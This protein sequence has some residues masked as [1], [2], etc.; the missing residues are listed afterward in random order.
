[1]TQ[2]KAFEHTL[3]NKIHKTN[4]PPTITKYIANYI[5]GRKAYT[6]FN[7]TQSKQRHLKTGVP[8]GG[9]L[10]PILFN[11]YMSDLPNP[12][13]NVYL[14]SY[15][16]DITTLSL[17]HNIQ[18]AQNQLQPYLEKIHKWTVDN[19]MKLSADKSTSTLF[20]LHPNEFN[21]KLNIHINNVLIPTV[22]NPKILGLTFDPKLTFNQHIDNTK[23]KATKTVKLLKALTSTT[24]GKQKETIVT[25]YKTITRPVIEHASTIWSSTASKTNIKKLQTVQNIA[26]RTATGCTADT[27]TQH[28]HNETLVLPLQNHLQ[29]HASQIRQKSQNPS[30]PLHKLIQHENP[31][32]Q[33]K[34]TI[35]QPN[36]SYTHII[37]TDPANVTSEN[38]KQNLKTIHTSIVQK[39]LADRLPNKILNEKPPTIHKSEESLSRKNRRILA[40]TRT[41]KSPLL[42]SYKHKIDPHTYP[43]SLCPLCNSHE[44]DSTH[45]FNCT[46]I[47]T[48][49]TPIALWKNPVEATALL[50]AWA[51]RL[52]DL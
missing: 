6:L 47:P 38:I 30:H 3:I 4:I 35:F 2:S 1:M 17:H 45:L 40:Q 25:T 27:N 51:L 7:Q 33:I 8:Q 19:D 50:E 49:L 9:V 20:T 41:N 16:D 39:Y 42:F 14:Y 31:K 28:L 10:S 29:L 23:E 32:R 36:N 43:S 34:A 46:Q 48:H 11:I 37:H 24:W 52:A 18:T 5:K 44:H 22:Q 15:A 12:P 13:E 26:L 21:Y